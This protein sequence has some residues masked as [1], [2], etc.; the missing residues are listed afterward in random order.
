MMV[1]PKPPGMV[2]RGEGAERHQRRIDWSFALGSKEVTVGQ[3]RAFRKE[4]QNDNWSPTDDC[5]VMNVSWYDAAAYCNW[6][7]AK[8]GIPRDQWCY[9]TLKVG[10]HFLGMA[11]AP[12]YLKLRGYRLPTEAEWEY[13]CRAGSDVGYCFGESVD[14]LGRYAWFDGN[15]LGKSRPVG[16]LKPNGFGLFDVPGNAWEWCQDVYRA[17]NKSI[18]DMSKEYIMVNTSVARV[19][20]GGSWGNNPVGCRAA[21]RNGGVPAG[22]YGYYGFRVC[23][24]LDG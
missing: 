22:R 13:A 5:P 11:M 6:L 24:R 3:F 20:R 7:S 21:C 10:K 1:I 2:W 9:Q 14:L 17:D 19:L 16:L 23:F 15:S 12:N 18:D 4:T 8:E